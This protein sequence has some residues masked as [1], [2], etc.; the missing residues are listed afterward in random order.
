MNPEEHRSL[1]HW[2]YYLTLEADIER[3]SRFVDITPDNYGVYSIEIA[4]LLLTA[5]SEVDVLARQLCEHLDPR[6]KADDI[7][8]Y[9]PILLR[10]IP[11]LT[12][13]PVDILRY[14][15][16]L[17]PWQNWLD[18]NP[19]EWW[20][21]HNKVKHRRHEYFHR[22]NLE[23]ILN[24]AAGLFLLTVYFYDLT[25]KISVLEPAPTLF[26]PRV[27]VARIQGRMGGGVGLWIGKLRS[28]RNNDE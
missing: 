18:N 19:P 8:A 24:A 17:T 6:D 23:N 21:A 11:S 2:N 27:G 4:R 3:L 26:E 13:E 22:A 28:R 5:C 15:L 16:E 12:Q 20:S 1:L 7:N 25:T 9:R 14:G 10:A